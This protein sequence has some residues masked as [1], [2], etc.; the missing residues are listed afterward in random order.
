ME[1][2]YRLHGARRVEAEI[3]E[4]LDFHFLRDYI[5]DTGIHQG[6]DFFL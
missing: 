2:I 5:L 3:I 1:A 4:L 6:V